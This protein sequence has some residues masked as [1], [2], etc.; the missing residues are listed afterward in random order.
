MKVTVFSRREEFRSFVIYTCSADCKRAW[1]SLSR[2]TDDPVQAV[3]VYLDTFELFAIRQKEGS[4]EL[5][6]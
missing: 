4:I 1:S 3:N 2:I 6:N 5:K